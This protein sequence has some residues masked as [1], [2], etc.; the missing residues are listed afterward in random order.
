MVIKLNQAKQKQIYKV[1]TVLGSDSL[2][3][4]LKELGIVKDTKLSITSFSIAKKCAVISVRG[5]YLCLKNNALAKVI[6]TNA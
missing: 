3:V 5:Y 4:R 6:V 2:S 1:V